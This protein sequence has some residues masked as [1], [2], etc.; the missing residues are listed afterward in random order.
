MKISELITDGS[1]ESR[2]TAT[3]AHLA[4]KAAA[5]RS[6]LRQLQ[7]ARAVVRM[8][9]H[10]GSLKAILASILSFSLISQSWVRA[11]SIS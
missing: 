3:P 7:I 6:L 10:S 2:Q 9:A 4:I 5:V 1:L 8:N 11:F